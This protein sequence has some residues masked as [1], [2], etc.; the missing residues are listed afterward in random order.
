MET[1]LVITLTTILLIIV[2]LALASFADYFANTS[3]NQKTCDHLFNQDEVIDLKIDPKCVKCNTPLSE[4][5]LQL[6]A[7]KT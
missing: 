4:V 6:N 3:S 7:N 5:A 2:A 1:L